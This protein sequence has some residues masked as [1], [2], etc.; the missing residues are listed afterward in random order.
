MIYRE[1][2]IMRL[3]EFHNTYTLNIFSDASIIGRPGQYHGCYG[4]VAVNQDN[5]IDTVYKLVSNTTNN[6]SEIKGIRAALSLA[7]KYKDQFKNINIFSDSQIS[8][9]GLKHYIYNW[10]YNPKTHQFFGSGKNP[11]ANQNVFVECHNMMV[12]LDKCPT[13]NIKIYHQAGH[14]G[15]LFDSL[16]NAC[17][18]FCSS[19]GIKGKV[20]L[21]FIRYI[22]TYNTFVDNMS[23]SILRRSVDEVRHGNYCDPIEF[24]PTQ[25]I[26]KY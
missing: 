14:V 7:Y 23:R 4:A 24:I 1:D 17:Q 19:N 10:K 26:N 2:I 8:V 9:F 12:E 11:I 20:D 22:S 21:N 25:K 6:N 13:C 5:V 16:V 18:V 15:K 3:P